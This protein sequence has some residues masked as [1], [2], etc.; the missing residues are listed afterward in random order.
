[1][2]KKTTQI[3]SKGVKLSDLEED[4]SDLLDPEVEEEWENLDFNGLTDYIKKMNKAYGCKIS[5]SGTK[6]EKY[7]NIK[8][9]MNTV[10][11]NRRQKLLDDARQQSK[12][13]TNELIINN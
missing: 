10:S 2:V 3:K 5:I 7:Q 12:I 11:E 13:N 4:I 6:S 9:F 8:E 1:M